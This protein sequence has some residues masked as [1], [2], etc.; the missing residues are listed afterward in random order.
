MSIEETNLASE[1]GE[2]RSNPRT[3]PSLRPGPGTNGVRQVSVLSPCLFNVYMDNLLGELRK[4]SVGTKIGNLFLGCLAYADDFVLI[5]PTASGL[6]KMLDICV[7]YVNGHHLILNSKKSAVIGF[8]KRGMSSVDLPEVSLDG[9]ILICQ[10]NINHLGVV[11]RY[12]LSRSCHSGFRKR[13]F[14]GAVNSAVARMGGSCLN[15]VA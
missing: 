7:R 12:A 5:S 13:K 15:D 10:E 3:P 8:I 1:S 4:S 2:V 6:Q 9:N 11:F 14:F